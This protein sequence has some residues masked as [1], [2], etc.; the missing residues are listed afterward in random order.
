[1]S[2]P[3]D[4]AAEL[5]FGDWRAR[6]DGNEPWMVTC[7]PLTA[8]ERRIVVFAPHMD[9]E[10][11]GCGGTICAHSAAGAWV[12]VAFM[13][14]GGNATAARK[15]E[16]ARAA[17]VLGVGEV[18][19]LDLP[20]TELRADIGAIERAHALLTRTRPESIYVPWPLDAHRDHFATSAI[21]AGAVALLGERAA[22]VTV[23]CYEV[24]T[25]LWANAVMD[26]T[27][28]FAAK[29][30][31]LAAYR[32]QFIGHD[33]SP[34]LGMSKFRAMALP[35][36]GSAEA[37]AEYDGATFVRLVDALTQS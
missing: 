14:D 10:A 13:T 27:P 2:V 4:P 34:A 18:V 35:G 25:P 24:W 9:D 16:A 12:T 36:P 19:H 3:T 37:F 33:P 20:D 23:R 8:S 7:R 5:L 6:R 31:A 30:E 21:V 1:M 32:S 22:S 11:I 29:Q 15:A 26:I 28:H 17:D